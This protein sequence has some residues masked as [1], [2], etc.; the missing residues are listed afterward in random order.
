M[1]FALRLV[2]GLLLFAATS[3]AFAADSLLKPA[4]VEQLVELLLPEQNPEV[5]NSFTSPASNIAIEAKDAAWL[6]F[7][8]FLPFLVLPQ[9]LLVYVVVKFRDRKDGRKPATFIHHN[10]L[11]IAWT[12]IP[13]VV[14]ILISLPMARLVYFTDEMPTDA[15]QQQDKLTVQLIGKSF[16]WI[17][18]YPEQQLE[19]AKFGFVNPYTESLGAVESGAET[20]L[21]A[22]VIFVSDQY[23]ELLFKSLDVNHAWYVPALGVK[24]DCYQDRWN[25]AWMT[26]IVFSDE[27]LAN[28]EHYLEGQCYE[29][30][31]QGHGIMMF[32]SIIVPDA[33]TFDHWVD[34]Q[35][36]QYDAFQVV[37]ASVAERMG[38]AEA[39][40]LDAALTAY[41]Q[42][43]SSVARLNAL[44]YWLGTNDLIAS[45][46][47]LDL[48][49][50]R[51]ADATAVLEAGAAARAAIRQRITDPT[52][53]A[54]LTGTAD[55][56]A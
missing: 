9:V 8:V 15:R 34:F 16:E 38:T 33:E 20:Q 17:W 52:S 47:I 6:S 36:H 40:A 14:V 27:Q 46:R 2:L 29:L 45:E 54:A 30:C 32:A 42:A 28:G 10:K 48:G 24:K 39:G 43:G 4:E 50:E 31:G 56:D 55:F 22:P 21:Q 51:A 12:A 11:E 44:L 49:P 3:S 26:P 13:L 18:N 19:V 41:L 37:K 23:T 1:P 25:Y 5:T 35:R 7:L 53:L